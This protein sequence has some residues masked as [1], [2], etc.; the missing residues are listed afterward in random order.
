MEIQRLDGTVLRLEG[1]LDDKDENIRDLLRQIAELKD[2]LDKAEG[3][4]KVHIQ[5][6]FVC[7][8]CGCVRVRVCVC[9]YGVC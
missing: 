8:V 9:V 4:L 1:E 2:R 5:L 6:V 3:R 7:V